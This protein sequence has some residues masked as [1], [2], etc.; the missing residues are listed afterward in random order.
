MVKNYNKR[1]KDMTLKEGDLVLRKVI[2]STKVKKHGKLTAEWEGPYV[3]P[4]VCRPGTYYLRT[5]DG[6]KLMRPRNIKHLNKYYPYNILYK[7][8]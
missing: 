3:V 2:M 4:K 1:V 8:L 5:I 6:I 7:F